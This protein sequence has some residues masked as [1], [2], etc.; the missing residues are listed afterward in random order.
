M[1]LSFKLSQYVF[2]FSYDVNE[3]KKGNGNDHSVGTDCCSLGV[4]W[5][6]QIK[7]PDILQKSSLASTASRSDPETPALKLEVFMCTV[8]CDH[9]VLENRRRME[10]QMLPAIF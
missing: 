9:F 10:T 3:V 7:S 1:L 4:S 8:L 2:V 5:W 6:R